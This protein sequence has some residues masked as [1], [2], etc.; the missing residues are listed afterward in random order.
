MQAAGS[1]VLAAVLLTALKLVVG[2]ATNSLGVLSEAAH[3][4]FDLLAAGMTFVAVR[5]A[6]APPDGDHPYGH[7]KVENL[8]AFVETLL[9]L[10]TCIWIIHEA[11]DRLFFNPVLVALPFGPP[12]SWLFPLLWI[13][14]V[15]ACSCA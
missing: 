11:I 7:G 15:R 10:I 5:I 1:S 12:P 4:A 3:S 14:R 9:L 6:S 8:S 13:T 2:L